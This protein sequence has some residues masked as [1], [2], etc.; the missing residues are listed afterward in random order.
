VIIVGNDGTRWYGIGVR[1]RTEKEVPASKL[2][3]HEHGNNH[4]AN[5]ESIHRIQRKMETVQLVE[6]E[7]E[8][9]DNQDPKKEQTVTDGKG[10]ERTGVHRGS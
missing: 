5:V 7:L 3:V 1:Y 2:I 6:S 4:P 8:A 10:G 9:R